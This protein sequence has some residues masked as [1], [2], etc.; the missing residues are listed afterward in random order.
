[1]NPSSPRLK[2]SISRIRLLPTDSAVVGACMF[3]RTL[4]AERPVTSDSL[5]QAHDERLIDAVV[6]RVDELVS[7]AVVHA[8]SDVEVICRIEEGRDTGTEVEVICRIDDGRWP[9]TPW[10]VTGGSSRQKEESAA[11]PELE[12]HAGEGG[13]E[14]AHQLAAT[15]EETCYGTGSPGRQAYAPAEYSM[16]FRLKVPAD[17]GETLSTHTDAREH[18]PPTMAP[19]VTTAAP[20]GSTLHVQHEGL[21]HSFLAEASELLAG[22][23][24]E[25]L[26][27]ALAGQLLVPR[28]ADWCGVW[29]SGIKSQMRLSRVWHADEQLIE[30][31]R[32][33]LEKNPPPYT[34]RA[35]GFPLPTLAGVINAD[36]GRAIALPLVAGGSC[37]GVIVLGSANHRQAAG[38]IHQVESMARLVAQAVVT[39]RQYSRQTTISRA[40][41][42]RQL[43]GSL[44][45]VPGLDTAVTYE[46]HEEAQTVGGDFYDLFPKGD[47]RWCFLLGDVQ[48]K[49]PEAMSLTGLARHMVR[50]LAGEGHS[51]ETVLQRLNVALTDDGAETAACGGE[52]AYGRLL[53]L[54][55]GELEPDTVSGVVHCRLASAGHPLPLRLFTNGTVEPAAE[56]Q[57]LLGVDRNAQFSADSFDLMPGEIMLCVTDGVTERRRGTQQLDDDDGLQNT[58]RRCTGLSA[59]A[60]ANRVR[61]AVYDFSTEPVGDD[62]AI[63]VVKALPPAAPMNVPNRPTPR[64]G[65]N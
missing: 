29:L 26:V 23:L 62:L 65:V 2:V 21:G 14:V 24:D 49:D 60:V 10:L 35:G 40:L 43:P 47:G 44:P 17:E 7:N 58:L 56:P 15:T 59:A 37:Q 64:R 11:L 18:S 30:P 52:H 32:E 57:I 61:Q 16:R 46:P 45:C 33:L 13:A 19:D 22:Q 5:V 20:D 42:S 1:M 3:M 51:V 31:L 8:E 6:L 38:V 12:Q 53:T 36:R 48:G 34:L 9:L 55:Y 63:L 25:D 54:L 4:L 27:A 28:V 39:A 50:F 41:Q